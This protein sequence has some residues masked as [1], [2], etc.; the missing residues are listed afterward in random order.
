MRNRKILATHILMRSVGLVGHMTPDNEK[1]FEKPL[2][3][4]FYDLDFVKN[5]SGAK[6][7]RNR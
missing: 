1:F 7:I 5:P 3:V 6:Y 4:V 2:L